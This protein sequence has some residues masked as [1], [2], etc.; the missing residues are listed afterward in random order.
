MVASVDDTWHSVARHTHTPRPIAGYKL[1]TVRYTAYGTEQAEGGWVK[2]LGA[3]LCTAR[4]RCHARSRGRM[5]AR[6]AQSARLDGAS[7]L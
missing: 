7:Q 6:L 1:T 4:P 3:P 2:A 5:G